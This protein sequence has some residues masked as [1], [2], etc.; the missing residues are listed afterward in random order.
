M[1]PS[2]IIA[3][4][5]LACC[6]LTGGASAQASQTSKAAPGKAYVS[7]DYQGI[8]KAVAA[9]KGK[10][11]VV[12]FWATWC[13]PCL[14]EI[15]HLMKMREEFPEAR[16]HLM[17]ISLDEDEKAL[18]GFLAKRKL[19]YPNY[20][21]DRSVLMGFRVSGVPRLIVYDPSGT[22][23]LSHEGYMEPD[24]LRELIRRHLPAKDAQ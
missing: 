7:A 23:V 1:R 14:M 12:N 8:L 9:Q 17:G 22:L 10:V 19:N 11:V 4:L 2:S 5:L 24:A 21:G 13:P 15:P 3:S 16:M 20:H 18:A 6:L